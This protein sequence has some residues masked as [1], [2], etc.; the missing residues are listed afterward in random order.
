MKIDESI[1]KEINKEME[2]IQAPHSLYEFVKNI[3]E[4][5]E[6]RANFEKP[7]ERKKGRRKF[8]FATAAVVSLGVLTGSAF[9]N[10][11]MAEMASKIPYLG[12][13]F[14][15]PIAE[16]IAETLE[17][18]GYKTAGIGMNMTAGEKPL[19]DIR[20]KGTEQYVK[21]EEDKVL[22]ILTGILGKRGYDNY[23][24]MVSD[25][26]EVSPALTEIV[27]QREMLGEKLKWDLQAAGYPIIDVNAFNPVV[28]VYI[29]IAEEAKA[30]EIQKAAIELLKAN[31]TSKQVQITTRDVSDDELENAWMFAMMSITEKFYLKKEY[32]VADISYS[33][34][35]EKVTITIN[36]SM[37]PSDA[38]TKETVTKI[39][40]EI[41]EFLDSE[42]VKTKIENQKY[43]LIVQDKNGIDFPF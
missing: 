23:E 22:K 40:K 25:T 4:E 7:T 16:V 30:V 17:K 14:H 11:T 8:Q 35:P 29:P 42:E 43:E 39:R 34:K 28:Q 26:N 31:G 5:S 20:L 9:L 37:S 33:Y 36:T 3:K 18:E 24:L 21:Q 10:P 6:M 32:R 38:E 1:K 12:Q 19:V 15:K 41:T 2:K 27:K 13:V